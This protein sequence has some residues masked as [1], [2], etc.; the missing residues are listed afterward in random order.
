VEDE[1]DLEGGVVSEAAEEEVVIVGEVVEV[2]G[3]FRSGIGLVQP[4][5]KYWR[6]Y[7]LKLASYHGSFTI[8]SIILH[9]FS[10][11]ALG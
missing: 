3:D 4:L 7:G 9:G 8:E 5:W 10:N 1:E 6:D 11:L 2:E